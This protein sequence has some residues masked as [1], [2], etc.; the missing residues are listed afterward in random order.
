MI[1]RLEPTTANNNVDRGKFRCFVYEK[2][3]DGQTILMAQ[4]LEETC[5]GLI[6]ASEGPRTM[7]ITAKPPTFRCNFPDY[8]TGREG[9][10]SVDNSLIYMFNQ[11]SSNY[12]VKETREGNV[13]EEATCIKQVFTS[14]QIA[15]RQ[16]Q[17][18]DNQ[19]LQQQQ[20]HSY[21]SSHSDTNYDQFL[22]QAT[23]NW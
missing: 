7:R 11:N 4:S 3:P 2:L 22:V 1:G 17:I 16:H 20:Y 12:Q 18:V 23:K 6:S 9:W 21:H 13:I 14:Q 10:V 19:Q 8:I 5:Y 15:R